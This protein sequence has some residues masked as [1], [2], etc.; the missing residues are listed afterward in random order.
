MSKARGER[1]RRII[2]NRITI[3]LGILTSFGMLAYHELFGP[4]L[5]EAGVG[6]FY[7][8]LPVFIIL[9]TG[10]IALAR[11]NIIINTAVVVFSFLLTYTL[12]VGIAGMLPSDPIINIQ[13]L[14]I[15]FLILASL[16]FFMN[17]L[18]NLAEGARKAGRLVVQGSTR[19]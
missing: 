15:E 7:F 1:G 14:P 16:V 13:Q 6:F 9:G 8:L 5:I 17:V 12:I 19:I 4:S 3:G 2:F 18:D 10:T 11:L